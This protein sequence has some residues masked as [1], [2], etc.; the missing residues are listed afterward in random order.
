MIDWE[1]YEPHSRYDPIT[2]EMLQTYSEVNERIQFVCGLLKKYRPLFTHHSAT[3]E[4]NGSRI[5]CKFEWQFH[6]CGRECDEDSFPTQY[7]LMPEAEIDAAEQLLKDQRDEAARQKKAA[8][9]ASRLAGKRRE[10]ERL[11]KELGE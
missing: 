9:E 1:T 3:P 10:F 6:G 8:E 11:R 5:D 2:E 4:V 7:L